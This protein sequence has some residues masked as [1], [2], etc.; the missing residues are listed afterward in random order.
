[1]PS[2]KRSLTNSGENG[3]G[4][5]HGAARP[6]RSPGRRINHKIPVVLQNEPASRREGAGVPPEAAIRSI[7]RKISICLHIA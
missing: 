1:M 6:G 5:L 2:K 3:Q 7:D 4:L